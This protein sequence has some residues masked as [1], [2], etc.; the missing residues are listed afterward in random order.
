MIN[1]GKSCNSYIYI[2]LTQMV[3]QI[4]KGSPV[5]ECIQHESLNQLCFQSLLPCVLMFSN[6]VML[7]LQD[8]FWQTLHSIKHQDVKIFQLFQVNTIID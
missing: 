8:H 7:T 4:F 6:A 1:N 2:I 5:W 3:S